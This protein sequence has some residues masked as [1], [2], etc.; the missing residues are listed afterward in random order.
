MTEKAN[1]EDV[2][3]GPGMAARHCGPMFANDRGHC[4]HFIGTPSMYSAE[5]TCSE[6][7]GGIKRS[8]WCKLFKKAVT[9]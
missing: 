7:K 8:K 5:G 9:K 4:T 6:V 1:K 2:D 3:F